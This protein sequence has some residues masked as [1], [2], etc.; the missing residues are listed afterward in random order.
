MAANSSNLFHLITIVNAAAK[1]FDEEHN[2]DAEY[3][4]KV[5]ENAGDFILWAW[6]VRASRVTKTSFSIDPNDIDLELFKIQRY[7]ACIS[8]VCAA[9]TAVPNGLPP[10]PQ[11]DQTNLA[12]LGLLNTTIS[13]QSDQQEEQ[14]KIL[15]KQVNHMIN[16]ENS[17][18]NCVKNLHEATIKMI[19]FASALDN[20]EVP[21]N[22]TNSCKPFMNSN[23]IALAEQELNQQFETRGM[24]KVSFATG[25][26]ANMYAGTFLWSSGNIPSNHLPF[27]FSEVKPIKAAEH[28]NRHLTLQLVLTQG[29]GLMLNKIKASNK[30]EVSAP[31]N[32][33]EMPIGNPSGDPSSILSGIPSGDPSRNPSGNPSSISSGNPS[34]DPSSFSISVPSRDPSS[35]LSDNP[36][37][38]PSSDPSGSPSSITSGNSSGDPPAKVAAGVQQSQQRQQWHNGSGAV[39][40]PVKAAAKAAAPAKGSVPANLAVPAKRPSRDP[41]SNPSGSGSS[42]L[43][44]MAAGRQQLRVGQRH[45]VNQSRYYGYCTFDL[46]CTPGPWKSGILLSSQ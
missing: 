24:N 21:D 13:R 8:T 40:T 2:A 42:T 46:N 7:Q 12:A 14:N 31:M 5:T 28:K 38:D 18:K 45:D 17:S 22:V 25:Y 26:T 36:S 32:F 35:I 4:T 37:E 44:S 34:G 9:W 33:N 20:K 43:G 30:Q 39:T 41:S 6:G 16:K 27:A 3:I 1:T 23:S 29:R 10:L 19:L 11:G 15:E